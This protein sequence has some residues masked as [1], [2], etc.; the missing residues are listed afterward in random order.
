MNRSYLHIIAASSFPHG[1]RDGLVVPVLGGLV[2]VAAAPAAR[3][4]VSAQLPRMW[5]WLLRAMTT[6]SASVKEDESGRAARVVAA[7]A[8]AGG[9]ALRCVLREAASEN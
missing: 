9:T 2:V 8:P 6:V 5:R 1:E 4:N 7:A 3:S